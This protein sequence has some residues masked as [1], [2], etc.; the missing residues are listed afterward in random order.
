VL[1]AL[2]SLRRR[3]ARTRIDSAPKGNP[4]ASQVSLLELYGVDAIF[5]IGANIGMSAEAYRAAG[6]SGPIV[7]FEPVPSLYA[8]LERRS[9]DDPLWQAAPLALGSERGFADIHVTG[10]HAGA[11]SLL[12]MT[13]NV[14]TH[15]PDQVV[16]RT[17]RIEVSTL[18]DVIG[19]YYPHG[20]RLFLKIDVQGYERRVLDGARKSLPRVVGMKLELSLV[21][22]YRG[23]TL[24]TEMLPLIYDLGYRAVSIERAWG[25]EKTQEI[26]QVDLTCFRVERVQS[27][28]A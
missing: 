16:V 26:F 2:F 13:D 1:Q 7:S 12:K 17:Q 20:D 3:N 25:N 14:V 28:H 22:N 5:D 6:F 18:D 4:P 10:G 19:E 24:L 9:Q 23:E 8:E 27:C 21:E 15:A 11:T